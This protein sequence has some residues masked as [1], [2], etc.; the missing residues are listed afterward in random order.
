MRLRDW[1]TIIATTVLI[2]AAYAYAQNHDA[3]AA[4]RDALVPP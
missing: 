4:A 3:E 2:S 1:L